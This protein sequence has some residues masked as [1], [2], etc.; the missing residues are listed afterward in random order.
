[1]AVRPGEAVP[2]VTADTTQRRTMLTVA[3]CGAALVS[4]AVCLG[5]QGLAPKAELRSI[6]ASDGVQSGRPFKS[7][8]KFSYPTAYMCR[9]TSRAIRC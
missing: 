4:V 7:R 3:A 2:N 6:V 1:M 5:A 9:R 8:S